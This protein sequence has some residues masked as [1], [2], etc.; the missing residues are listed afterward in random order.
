[1]SARRLF[2]SEA[3]W[4]LTYLECP[5]CMLA[6][7]GAPPTLYQLEDAI[8]NIATDPEATPAILFLLAHLPRMRQLLVALPFAMPRC[9]RMLR[10]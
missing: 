1:M 8:T 7:V 5:S 3:R 10:V 2:P 9:W 6:L 4:R